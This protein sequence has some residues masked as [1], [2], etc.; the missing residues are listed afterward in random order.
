M[1]QCSIWHSFLFTILII[2]TVRDFQEEQRVVRNTLEK[3]TER[4]GCGLHLMNY[5]FKSNLSVFQS[6]L[7]NFK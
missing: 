3:L 7:N 1:Q 4:S 2:K 5:I 6:K